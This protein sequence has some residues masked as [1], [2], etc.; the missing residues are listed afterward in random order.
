MWSKTDKWPYDIAFN[1][2]WC[3]IIWNITPHWGESGSDIDISFNTIN[4][5]KAYCSQASRW[6]N[7]DLTDIVFFSHLIRQL[8]TSHKQNLPGELN[9]PLSIFQ[10]LRWRP[11]WPPASTIHNDGPLSATPAAE[12]CSNDT[13]LVTHPDF[14]WR[15]IPC[16]LK[17]I[18]YYELFVR[19]E[20]NFVYVQSRLSSASKIPSYHNY[21]LWICTYWI[22]ILKLGKIQA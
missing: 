15:L 18:Y 22:H 11:R 13:E 17:R 21:K 16:V 10:N 5:Q 3:F 4:I 2:S 1:K 6:A 7:L 14:L 12:R 8:Q 9:S 20:I 19:D